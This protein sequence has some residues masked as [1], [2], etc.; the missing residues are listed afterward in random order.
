MVFVYIVFDD[1]FIF[2]VSIVI[3]VFDIVLF[4]LIFS[5]MFFVL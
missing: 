5:C 3:D 4:F 1:K 2:D